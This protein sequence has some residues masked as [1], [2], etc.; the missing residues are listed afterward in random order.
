MLK[1]ITLHIQQHWAPQMEVRCSC[2]GLAPAILALHHSVWWLHLYQRKVYGLKW[3]L[4]ESESKS[5]SCFCEWACECVQTH[6][7]FGARNSCRQVEF[8]P[9]P[10]DPLS[11]GL[12]TAIINDCRA[13]EYKLKYSKNQLLHQKSLMQTGWY[14]CTEFYTTVYNCTY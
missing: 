11:D 6:G 13:T 9:R 3:R 12:W 14:I 10:P 1:G 7:A 2:K 5:K 8:G 4:K